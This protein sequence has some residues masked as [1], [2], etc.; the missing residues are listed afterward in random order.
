MTEK[1]DSS[2]LHW[3]ALEVEATLDQLQ[4]S[5]TGLRTDE[6]SIRLGQTGRNIVKR[7]HHFQAIKIFAR[8][9]QD[10]LTILLLASVAI[11]WYLKDSQTTIVLAII[12]T[13][14]VLI[15]FFEEYKADRVMEGLQKLLKP[16]AKVMRAGKI[17]EI[18]AEDIVPGDIIKLEAGD[19]VP[20]DIRLISVDGLMSNDYALTGESTPSS[21]F[22]QALGETVGLADRSNMVYMGT[23]IAAGVGEGVVVATG[24]RT[25]LGKIASLSQEA[26]AER[27]PLQKEIAHLAKRITQGT[28]TLTAILIP[29]AMGAKFGLRESFIFAIGIASAMI[30]QGLPAEVNVA[31]SQAAG[32]L[33]KAKALVKRLTAVETLGATQIICTDKTGTLTKNEMTV[34]SLFTA[35]EVYKIEGT[36]F[37]PQG[38]VIDSVGDVLSIEK[39]NALSLVADCCVQA[40]NASINPP[41]GKHASW[42]SIGD[43]TE[44]A[45]ITLAQKIAHKEKTVYTR[46]KEFPFDSDRKRMSVVSQ[47]GQKKYI[48]CK[49]S[50]ESVAQISTHILVNGK[51]VKLSKAHREQ[52]TRYS[53][54]QAD[55]AMRNLALAYKEV[56]TDADQASIDEVESGLTFLA[57]SSMIDPPRDDVAEAMRAARQ[58]NMLVTIITGDEAR[59]A[60]AIAEQI[61]FGGGGE[62][63]TTDHQQLTKLSDKDIV[64]QILTGRAIFARVSP[65]DK[66]RIVEA[67]KRAGYVIAVTGDGINDAPAL[68]RA[69]IG[70]AMGKIGS[71][72][73]KDSAEI[74]LLDDSFHTLVSAIQ[75]GRVIF[76]NI[77]K[78]ALSC[79]TS[80]TA[81]LTLVLIS[82]GIGALFG[83]P[84]AITV[85]QI[86]AIDLMAELFPLAALG[87][88]P[89]TSNLMSEQ[90]RNPK[91]HIVNTRA[92]IDLATS[93]LV[94]GG[95]AYLNFVMVFL[96]AGEPIASA[97]PIYTQATTVAYVTVALCQ[98]ATVLSRRTAPGKSILSKYLFS[99][100]HLWVA[101]GLSLGG[102]ILITYLPLLSKFIGNASINLAMWVMALVASFFYLILRE[103]VKVKWQ[104][105]AS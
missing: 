11:S 36:G 84:M 29:I 85:T 82:I 103:V 31:L 83:L 34:T 57:I 5:S 21:C 79:L 28:I 7:T 48:F 35:S 75:Q 65:S 62:I 30:P 46:I 17:Q 95:L 22:T 90:P 23:T 72:V 61:G 50:P 88:D 45:L 89:A 60:T 64:K 37:L 27:S 2:S 105:S 87:W 41:D 6:A 10:L 78:T 3:H 67:L 33:A 81:E 42:Y 25:E 100:W 16:T 53:T 13:V 68:K 66:L 9:F 102:I 43:P 92:I 52:I 76:R 55:Q 18:D 97:S 14:N 38:R 59:T 94:M 12:I 4:S 101:F 99:N 8:Q 44:G 51:S 74:V 49:G 73:A 71:E 40:N 86:L 15:G 104:L 70:V 24:M 47:D 54:H 19:G 58:A 69:D 56:S 77:R 32:K 91:D 63:L 39:A 26:H 93:G 80:N 98:F 96:V 20:A 1:L